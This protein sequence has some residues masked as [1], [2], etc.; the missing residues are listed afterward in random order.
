MWIASCTKL[1]TAISAVQCVEKG[2][3]DLDD[4]ISTVLSEWKDPKI[5]VGF[6]DASGEPIMQ[7]AKGKITL[8]MLLTHQSGMG[9]GF[10]QPLLEKFVDYRKN[11][12]EA[13]SKLVSAQPH[14][15]YLK[16]SLKFIFLID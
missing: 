1:M 4:D 12:E 3:L 9:Y 16:S 15:T 7:T 13:R 2:L 5:L 6:E 10:I 8:R 14:L 11:A